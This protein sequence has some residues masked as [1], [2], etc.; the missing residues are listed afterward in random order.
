MLPSTFPEIY[1]DH[2]WQNG[3]TASLRLVVPLAD[4]TGDGVEELF[5]SNK[6]HF[7][8]LDGRDGKEICQENT[9]SVRAGRAGPAASGA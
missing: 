4:L 6:T 1:N 2:L 7:T 5:V 9:G 3:P 8:I